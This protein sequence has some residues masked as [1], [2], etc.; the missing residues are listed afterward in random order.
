[1]RAFLL[2]IRLGYEDAEE[3]LAELNDLARTA[4]YDVAGATIARLRQINPR[5][6]V[7]AGKIEELKHLKEQLNF[8]LLIVDESLSPSQA[9]SIEDDLQCAVLDRAGLILDI[10]A[11]RAHSREGKLQVEFAELEYML[12]RLYNKGIEMSRLGGIVGLRGGG[13]EPYFEKQRRRIRRQ[14]HSVKQELE[15][16]ALQRETRRKI[17]KRQGLTVFAL[18]G[19]TNA[20]KSSVLNAL[21]GAE[22]LVDDRLFATLDPTTRR[23]FVPKLNKEVLVTDT[24]GFIRKL[25]HALVESF[26][27]TLEEVTEADF[28]IHVVDPTVREPFKHMDAVSRALDEIGAATKPTITA[29]NKIDLLTDAQVKEVELMARTLK[30]SVLISVYQHKGLD[31]LLNHM[32]ALATQIPSPS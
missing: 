5:S 26:K 14:I 6:F 17:R 4:G 16:I 24:V 27:A 8:E 28:L 22:V 25:P 18:V 7:G 23:V 12:P 2:G 19:Y 20:G 31:E 32:A 3:T 30:P 29:Y 13:G 10:F 1:M 9:K 21:S 11:L 15:S